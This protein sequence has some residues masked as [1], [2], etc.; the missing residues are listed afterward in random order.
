MTLSLRILSGSKM[1]KKVDR[2]DEAFDR[3]SS[4]YA[5]ILLLSY[6]EV[7]V[8]SELTPS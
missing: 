7:I 6:H 2:T 1:L 4:Y 8:K 3:M 5:R